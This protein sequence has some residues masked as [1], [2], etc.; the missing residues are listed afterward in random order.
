MTIDLIVRYASLLLGLLD[1]TAAV[2]LWVVARTM[3]SP[4]EFLSL[5]RRVDL[6]EQRPGWAPVN[7]LRDDIRELSGEVKAM[8]EKVDATNEKVD[9]LA[10]RVGRIESYLLDH[11]K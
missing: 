3:V 7:E 8:R 1:V 11:G 2:T 10:G 4:R 9:E 5:R 6:L